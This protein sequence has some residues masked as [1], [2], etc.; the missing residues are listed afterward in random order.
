MTKQK[1]PCPYC[2][3]KNTEPSWGAAGYLQCNKCGREFPDPNWKDQSEKLFQRRRRSLNEEVLKE[4]ERIHKKFGYVSETRYYVIT[5]GRVPPGFATN[6]KNEAIR[7]LIEARKVDPNA[8]VCDNVDFGTYP[9]LER[10][11]IRMKMRERKTN[12]VKRKVK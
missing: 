2:K 3:S 11:A 12:Q 10:L 9:D 7:L 8:W 6:D 5:G 4:R 1:T